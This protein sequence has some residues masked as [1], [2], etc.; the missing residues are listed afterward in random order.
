MEASASNSASWI[1][2][3]LILAVAL[4]VLGGFGCAWRGRCAAVQ[5]CNQTSMALFFLRASGQVEAQLKLGFSPHL[6]CSPM[7]RILV[8]DLDGMN[9][10]TGD[11]EK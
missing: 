11:I 9:G 8:E 6:P 2:R 1:V 3:V 4:F 10:L 5:L 7:T